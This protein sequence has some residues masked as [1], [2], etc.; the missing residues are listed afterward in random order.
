MAVLAYHKVNDRFEFGMTNVKPEMFIRQIFAL[1][2]SGYKFSCS[3]YEAAASDENVGLTFDDGYDCF[4][5]NVVPFLISVG[6]SAIVFVI[7]DFIGK[8]NSWDLRLS[9]KPFVHMNEAQIKEVSQLGFEVGSHSC[10]H[11]D[12]TRIDRETARDELSDSKKLIEDLTG[13]EVNSV[14][15][16]YGRHNSNVVSLASELGY[17]N[18]YGLGSN[19]SGGV[20]KRIPV[21][22]IDTPATVRKKV[23]MNRLEILKSDLIHSFANISALISVRRTEMAA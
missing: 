20:I 1:K 16:P 21:Y 19:V 6:A 9:R 5:T 10:S 4:Y 12:L 11:R 22:K 14:S 18:Q 23:S 3:P 7:T 2:E 8:E 13:K 15:F 17:L